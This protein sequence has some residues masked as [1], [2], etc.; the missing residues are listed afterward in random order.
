MKG[1]FTGC[2][3]GETFIDKSPPTQWLRFF[4]EQ[5]APDKTTTDNMKIRVDEGGKLGMS[6]EFRRVCYLLG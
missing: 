6:H 4:F 3:H 1:T 2:E 5:Q